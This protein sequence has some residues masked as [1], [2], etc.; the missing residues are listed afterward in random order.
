MAPPKRPWFR[1]Y[2]EAVHDR[3]LRRLKPEVRW[4]FVAC[5]AAA[6]QSP[7]P[8]VLL[9]GEGQ[10]MDHDDLADFAGVTRRQVETGTDALQDAGVLAYDT[11]RDVWLV[12]AFT[13]RQF[14]SD[15]VTARTR[16]HRTTK[17]RS[18][19]G[20]AT[21]NG[22]PPE[23]DT[24]TEPPPPTSAEPPAAPTSGGGGIDAVLDEAARLLAE[25][26]ADR[27]GNE[28]GSRVGYVRA[29]TTAI[30]RDQEPTWRA[31]LD[32]EP[33]TTAEQLATGQPQTAAGDRDVAAMR[34]RIKL[35]ERR[36]RG[37]V[38]PDCEGRGV[39][40]LGDGTVTDC[41]CKLVK[42]S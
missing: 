33:F 2:V 15:D 36:K 38:C 34:A 27:R 31:I 17:E 16:K 39:V 40:E 26:E 22:T 35:T 1:F 5:L 23:A 37:D 12:P 8:G 14:E 9:V 30:R 18:K 19:N 21:A 6:R 42:A 3:K 11:E 20:D 10:P 41:A 29:R 13:R 24:E 28:I 4:L 25:G 7:E 32:V